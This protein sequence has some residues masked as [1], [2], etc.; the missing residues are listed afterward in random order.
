[1]RTAWAFAVTCL[2]PACAAPLGPR[3]APRPALAAAT[4]P[5]GAPGVL[6]LP[7][8][9]PDDEGVRHLPPRRYGVPSWG[10]S[11]A[12]ARSQRYRPPPAPVP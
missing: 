5:T 4:A 3:E 11:G 12:R 10:L 8:P 9:A 2:V 1:M 6:L 7:R